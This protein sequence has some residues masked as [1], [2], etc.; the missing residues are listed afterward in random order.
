MLEYTT[1]AHH[2]Y[3]FTPNYS[4]RCLLLFYV[5]QHFSLQLSNQRR[6]GM[7]GYETMHCSHIAV[8]EQRHLTPCP[9]TDSLW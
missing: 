2:F 4:E 8:P 1:W 3:E 7:Q 6:F 9:D 5:L